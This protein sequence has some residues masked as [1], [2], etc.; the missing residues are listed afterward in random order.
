[1]PSHRREIE[2]ER[3]GNHDH[4]RIQATVDVKSGVHINPRLRWLDHWHIML[5]CV[6]YLEAARARAITIS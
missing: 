5:D 3:Q 6:D 2:R 1:M 4:E